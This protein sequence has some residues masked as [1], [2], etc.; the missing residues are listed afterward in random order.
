MQFLAWLE[1]TPIS[2]WVREAPTLWAFP[3]VLYLHTLGLAIVAGLSVTV[4]LFVLKFPDRLSMPALQYFFPAIWLG[5]TINLASGI[6]LLLAY[7]TKAL[8]DPVFY[9]KLTLIAAAMTQV[10]WLR[11]RVF[12]A[13]DRAAAADARIRASA[14]VALG[15]WAGAILT[16]RL[17]AYT[18][19]YLMADDLFSGF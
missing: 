17:L 1:Q 16:G 4:N 18:Y 14:M 15:C 8:T 11:L 2:L 19:R 7:P 12:C 9:L 6:L 5:F 10:E 13:A 3:F